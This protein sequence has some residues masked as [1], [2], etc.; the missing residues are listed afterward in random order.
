MLFRSDL[1]QKTYD[2]GSRE[3]LLVESQEAY[4]HPRMQ[5]QVEQVR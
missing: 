5:F 2:A 3:L 4:A 1:L